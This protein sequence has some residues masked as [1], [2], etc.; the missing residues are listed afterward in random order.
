MVV[1]L[2]NV[3]EQ[4]YHDLRGEEIARC[5][6]WGKR[7]DLFKSL[8]VATGMA[9]MV[10]SWP[11]KAE[12]RRSFRWLAP[13]ETTFGHHR[14]LF[15]G[16]WDGP[17]LRIPLSWVFYAWHVLGHTGSGD[18][19][20]I[21]NYELIYVIA[22]WVVRLRRRVRFVLDY[23]DGKHLIDRSWSRVLSGL[24][25]VLGRPLISAALVA[26]PS[27]GTRLGAQIPRELV[28][29]FLEKQPTPPVA[30][31]GI[32][33]FIYSGSLDRTRGVD[34]LLAASM[35]LPQT[36]WHLDITGSGPL[37]NEIAQKIKDR[38]L[39]ERV[40]F[41]RSL[42]AARLSDLLSKCQVGLNCQ[43]PSDPISGVTF[44]SKLFHYLS[45]GL[46]VLSSKASAVE[47]VCGMACRYYEA[48][49]PEALAQAM[50]DLIQNYDCIRKEIRDISGEYSVEATAHR[51]KRLLDEASGDSRHGDG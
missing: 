28:P 42:P 10:L 31:D 49:T 19:I 20:I 3:Y 36:G 48:E 32:L 14:Q 34:L 25:E 17:K 24:A 11:P 35:L 41:H 15:S 43:R 39:G 23:E 44:P 22:A 7:R 2:S 40:Y 5:L 27:L 26:H 46:L 13:V 1:V 9:V 50:A 16:N 33:R 6:S 8:E 30:G 51:L 4:A 45:S 38:N 12:K 21:D 18:I 47:Q 37:E 29:G